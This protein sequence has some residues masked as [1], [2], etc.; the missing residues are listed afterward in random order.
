MQYDNI[1]IV[2]LNIYIYNFSHY[3]I[4]YNKPMNENVNKHMFQT[5]PIKENN[6]NYAN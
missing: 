5:N 6:I 3:Q 1:Y 2:L 4:M